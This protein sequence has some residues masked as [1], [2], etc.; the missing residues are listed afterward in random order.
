MT[1]TDVATIWCGRGIHDGVRYWEHG[2]RFV[3]EQCHGQAGW[4]ELDLFR[5]R[6]PRDL[7][8]A[9]VMIVL[10]AAICRFIAMTLLLIVESSHPAAQT[11]HHLLALAFEAM[12]AFGTVG[13]SAGVTPLLT[14]AGKV[15]ILV[16]MFIGRVGPLMLAIHLCRPASP[17]HARHPEESVS[18]G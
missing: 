11:E 15:I 4:Q 18:L 5:R 6:G 1:F 17:W 14:W 13:L 2:S 12:S 3:N 7:I 9:A 8:G 16:L 10:M